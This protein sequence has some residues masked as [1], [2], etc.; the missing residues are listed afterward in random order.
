M[1]FLK[2]LN[3]GKN[4]ALFLTGTGLFYLL[5]CTVP[6]LAV[7]KNVTDIYKVGTYHI[8]S[9]SSYMVD[10]D[11]SLTSVIFG[12]T[13]VAFFKMISNGCF[14]VNKLMWQV[15]D[16]IIEKLYKGAEMDR[17][18][19][20][21][22]TFSQN[23]YNS[24]F[25]V[26]GLTLIGIYVLYVFYLKMFKSPQQ[27]TSAFIKMCLIVGFSVVWFGHG[28]VASQGEKFT[29]NID[30]WST[31]VEGLIFQATNGVEGLEVATNS[32][33]AIKQIRN[34]Y[35]QKAVVDPYLLLNYGTTNLQELDNA[36]IN[37]AEFLAKKYTDKDKETISDKLDDAKTE[38]ENKNYRQYI[39][40]ESGLYKA[41]VGAMTPLLNMTIGN[42]ILMIGMVRFI[43]QLGAMLMLIAL[44]FLLILSFFPTLDYLLFKGF[45][46]F[47][48]FMFQKSIYSVLILVA[49][50][51]FNVVDTLIPMG[52]IVSFIVN[53]M[54]KG[55]IGLIAFF[56]RKTILQKLG[57]GQADA[58]LRSV[59]HGA[60]QAK[61]ETKERVRSGIDRTQKLAL[62]T[63]SA[64]GYG[65]RGGVAAIN[66]IQSLN[67]NL[68]NLKNR[69]NE[70][71]STNGR[72][73]NPMEI[74]MRNKQQIP[75]SGKKVIYG[76]HIKGQPSNLNK[77]GVTT[78]VGLPFNPMKNRTVQNGEQSQK[79]NPPRL[80]TL[81]RNP[82]N[83]AGQKIP[84]INRTIP[85][86]TLDSR[87]SQPREN[88]RRLNHSNVRVTRTPID[89]TGQ[90]IPLINPYTPHLVLN[91]KFHSD[92]KQIQNLT[93]QYRKEVQ[94][95]EE[96]VIKKN[97]VRSL[98]SGRTPQRK[99]GGI[100][101]K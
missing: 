27:A 62:K 17:L 65:Y 90:K 87:Y 23:I 38:E 18:I 26:F 92:A 42:P 82:I 60:Q 80:M 63:A 44:P 83:Y 9:F 32:D 3:I 14:Y 51:V 61:Q 46:S 64:T 57:L 2:K 89:R 101:E 88:V 85:R 74:G 96:K 98:P 31:S 93:N 13:G 99:L 43:F 19:H 34:M 77:E 7:G 36:G 33:D 6:A 72:V 53:M 22:F 84:L 50:L 11:F 73:I 94:P 66:G 21:F 15:N 25:N 75:Y 29:K 52:T 37:P 30:T 71:R 79:M 68:Q 16:A 81:T 49:F 97:Q 86:V 58:T 59:K 35:Y 78:P 10:A 67:R 28:N 100:Y 8:D 55:I 39:K 1:K 40:P 5:I 56:K 95:L 69:P 12:D 70:A 48:G 47:V 24:L 45:R 91:K 4:K 41:V 76:N 20:T 54:I